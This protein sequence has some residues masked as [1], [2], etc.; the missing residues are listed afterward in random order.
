[1]FYIQYV[2]IIYSNLST[3]R[4]DSV[5]SVDSPKRL[6]ACNQTWISSSKYARSNIIVNPRRIPAFCRKKKE[7]FDISLKSEPCI[8][9]GNYTMMQKN[10]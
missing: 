6:P 4:S 1:M 7:H 5:D 2:F 8:N 3:L 9:S 10:K